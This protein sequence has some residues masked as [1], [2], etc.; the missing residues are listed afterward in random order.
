MTS[1]HAFPPKYSNL[2]KFHGVALY[3]LIP[4][5]SLQ[6]LK[7]AH[8][9]AQLSHLLTRFNFT[10]QP[11]QS[12]RGESYKSNLTKFY[13]SLNSFSAFETK[14]NEREKKLCFHRISPK[15]KKNLGARTGYSN[16]LS[17]SSNFVE[18]FD[19]ERKEI[20]NNNKNNNI[21]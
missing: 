5:T 11:F 7:N 14:R 12:E 8:K 13:V 16:P 21:T 1:H 17:P 20:T 6:K 19:L 18:C 9:S 2:V 15:Y 10:F 3:F 4:L